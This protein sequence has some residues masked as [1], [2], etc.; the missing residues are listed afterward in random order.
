MAVAGILC[1]GPLFGNS[2][3]SIPSCFGALT[4][5][6]NIQELIRQPPSMMG[7]IDND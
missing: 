4:S 2:L 7:S 5:I 3:S 1:L 6:P